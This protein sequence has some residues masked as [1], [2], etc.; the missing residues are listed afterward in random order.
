MKLFSENSGPM[1]NYFHPQN[2]R[3]GYKLVDFLLSIPT[4]L[5]GLTIFSQDEVELFS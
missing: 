2:I 5:S 4:S 1:G 3:N